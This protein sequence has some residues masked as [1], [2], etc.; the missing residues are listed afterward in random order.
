MKK[1]RC[2]GT[3][4][5]PPGIHRHPATMI[6]RIRLRDGRSG[7]AICLLGGDSWIRQR[8]PGCSNAERRDHVT[9]RKS[10]LTEP[11]SRRKAGMTIILWCL[12]TP[13]RWGVVPRS[14]HPYREGRV[15][16]FPSCDRDHGTA[17]FSANDLYPVAGTGQ[18]WHSSVGTYRR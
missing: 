12:L 1:T 16:P 14:T 3:S 9:I 8:R 13:P 15:W 5:Y 10:F 17:A 18:N 4:L 11:R 2:F 6:P 7:D